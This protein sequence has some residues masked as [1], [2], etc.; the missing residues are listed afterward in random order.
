MIGEGRNMV[1]ASRIECFIRRFLCVGQRFFGLL[2]L[3]GLWIHM[4]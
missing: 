3:D 1:K 2:C 4:E